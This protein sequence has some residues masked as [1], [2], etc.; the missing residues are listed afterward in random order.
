MLF[1]QMF[2]RLK[3]AHS[4]RTQA[5]TDVAVDESGVPTRFAWRGRKYVVLAVLLS[6]LESAAWWRGGRDYSVWRIEA[7]PSG[8]DQNQSQ[9]NR[10]S[11]Q[12]ES[13]VYSQDI[14]SQIL[15]ASSI[16]IYDIAQSNNS[17]FIRRVMD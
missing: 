12:V 4:Y 7:R 6:W 10:D 2:E 14:T 1:E 13:D 11:S 8:S 17:W 16:G 5:L 9:L 3:M 15:P